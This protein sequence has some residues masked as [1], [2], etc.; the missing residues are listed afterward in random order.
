[1][2]R[3]LNDA[4]QDV[5]FALR[6]FRRR[7]G[8]V[9]LAVPTLALGVGATTAVYSIVHAVLLRPLP[10]QDPD[11][12]VLIWD[13]DVREQRQKTVSYT[14]FEEY[15]RNANLIEQVSAS[16]RSYPLL[17]LQRCDQAVAGGL[18]HGRLLR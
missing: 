7:P 10:Y 11:R 1:M 9:V 8:F 18:G 3:W 17:T 6:L 4:W 12:L 2:N 15:S 5:R 13:N 16:R 14:H